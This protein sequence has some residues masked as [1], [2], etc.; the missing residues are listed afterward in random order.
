MPASTLIC[1]VYPTLVEVFDYSHS[2]PKEIAKVPF[3]FGPLDQFTVVQDLERGYIQVSGFAKSGYVRYQIY[4]KDGTYT[5]HQGRKK[6]GIKPRAPFERL[7]LGS[8][9]QQKW[10]DIAS[11]C[12]MR[13]VLAIW[14]TLGQ[15]APSLPDTIF[16]GSSL[17]S[18]VQSGELDAFKALF[19]AGFDPG[20]VPR[21]FDADHLGYN[22]PVVA[23]QNISPLLLLTEVAKS[24]RSLFFVEQERIFSILPKLDTKFHCGSLT[25]IR[26]V[27]G[28]HISIDWTKHLIRTLEIT[29]A[30]D[31]TICFNFQKEVKLFRMRLNKKESGAYFKVNDSLTIEK[32]KKYY[33]DSFQT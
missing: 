4:S 26:T 18:L 3:S 21:L 15:C 2:I 31:D 30:V 10:P 20:F 12:D 22:L 19:Q 24:I 1:R 16:T 8:N 13:E 6:P 7:Y 11:R 28:H 14:Y 5:I 27:R 9:K 33:I 32:G 23:E 17:V 29:A 25:D